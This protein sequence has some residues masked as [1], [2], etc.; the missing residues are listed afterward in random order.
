[1]KKISVIIP[2]Y[3][4]EK[5]LR[6]CLESVAN[7]TLHED[8]EVIII[9]DGS[10]DNSQKII[11][12]YVEKYPTV[13]KSFVKE[14]GG[15]GDARNYGLN[16]ATGEY[17]SFVDSDDVIR[18]DMYEKLYN[19]AK[20]K[21][22]DIVMCDIQWFYEDGRR[23]QRNM[24]PSFLKGLT[25]ENYILSDP[26][27]CNKIF[28]RKIWV[29]NNINFPT[30]IWYEDFAIIPT[31]IKYGNRLAYIEEELY[32]YRQRENSTMNNLEYTPKLLDIIDACDILYQFLANTK[33]IQ[34]VE[35]LYIFKLIYYS[36]YTFMEYN[37]YDDIKTCIKVVLEKFPNWRKNKY[38]QQKPIIFKI[39]CEI[40][41]RNRFKTAK[42]LIKIRGK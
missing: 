3:N 15:Q 25:V 22:Y 21:D 40:M 23:E 30:K 36:A 12:E 18:T 41:V 1:M 14:N 38:Y 33:Y 35:Y 6:E 27:P 19:K 13:F 16:Y 2:V 39:F 20:E 17:L 32:F 4:V 34:E 7:Q 9:N 11:D 24:I 8:M 42:L 29:D 31:L 26:S 5:Y 10:T 28:K 37:K